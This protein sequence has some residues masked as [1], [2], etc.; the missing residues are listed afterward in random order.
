MRILRA[1]C[2]LLL[3]HDWFNGGEACLDCGEPRPLGWQP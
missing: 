2:G 1:L 3:G